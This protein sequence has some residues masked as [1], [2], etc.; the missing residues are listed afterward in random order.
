[1]PFAHI[2]PFCLK[3]RV[4][5]QHYVYLKFIENLFS[6]PLCKSLS[7]KVLMKITSFESYKLQLVLIPLK[8]KTYCYRS[9]I[10]QLQ[11]F[12]NHLTKHSIPFWAINPTVS[13]SSR[14]EEKETF[15]LT[16]FVFWDMLCFI[17]FEKLHRSKQMKQN[18]TI[19]QDNILPPYSPYYC[20]SCLRKL[21]IQFILALSLKKKHEYVIL[22]W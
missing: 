20:C 12:S 4:N 7:A 17:F 6:V 16:K 13:F 8:I 22:I 2:C 9:N 15:H 1:M 5:Y 11:S 19:I 10:R 18:L 21:V 14:F 3:K